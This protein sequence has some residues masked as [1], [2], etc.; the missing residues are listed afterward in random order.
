MRLE[1]KTAVIVGAGQ[2]PGETIGN[3]RATAI[4]FA[5]E[6]ARVFLVDRDLAA[7]EETAAIIRA[8]GFE[9][10][11]HQA[12]I[13]READCIAMA[14]AATAINDPNDGIQSCVEE[15]QR[16]RDILL[17]ELRDFTVV[18][19]HGGWSFLVDVSPLGFDSPT[20]SKR[21]LEL[22]KIAATPMVNWGSASS[23]KYVRIAFANEPVQ[24][25][26]GIG[27]RFRTALT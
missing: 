20:A 16:R 15:W 14:A 1:G 12:D 25:L 18:P 27:Q 10:I 21:L 17:D 24:R 8:E 11:C 7:A 4:L 22:G 5:R 23:G 19:P 9:A 26:Q 2:T 3:G 13:A 6:G